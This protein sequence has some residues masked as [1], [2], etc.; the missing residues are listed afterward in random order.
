MCDVCLVLKCTRWEIFRVDIFTNARHTTL[1]PHFPGH[2]LFVRNEELFASLVTFKTEQ[3]ECPISN[4][5]T[6]VCFAER[7]LCPGFTFES[8]LLRAVCIESF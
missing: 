3:S 2:F 7:A 1:M 4:G 6:M 8:E 5:E